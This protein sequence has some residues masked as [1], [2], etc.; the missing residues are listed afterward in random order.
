MVLATI[1]ATSTQS[2][3]LPVVRDLETVGLTVELNDSWEQQGSDTRSR[4]G[5]FEFGFTFLVDVDISD[6]STYKFDELYVERHDY[7]DQE[8][9]NRWIRGEGGRNLGTDVVVDDHVFFEEGELGFEQSTV[10]LYRQER[11]KESH[12]RSS[13]YIVYAVD[14]SRAYLIKVGGIESQFEADEAPYRQILKS[15][16]LR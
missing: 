15:I 9:R 6:P 3:Q 1:L 13:G 16:V 10:F 4:D 11:G 12:Q 14:G 8:K 2:P 5:Q 7:F